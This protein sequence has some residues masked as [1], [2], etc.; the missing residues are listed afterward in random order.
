VVL[1]SEYNE[2]P[3]PYNGW[4]IYQQP[5]DTFAFVPQPGNGF[6]VAGPD[7]PAHGNLIVASNWYHL[8]VTDD[9]T[10]F[11]VYINGELR[12][13]FAVSGDQYIADGVGINPDGSAGLGGA[14]GGNFVIGQRTDG[15]WNTFE[16][17]VDDTAV[18]NYALTPQQVAL[19]YAD[20]A[21]LT[22]AKSGGNAALTWP[23][24][25]L[26]QST[27]LAGAFTDVVGAT[28][29]YTNSLSGPGAIFYRVRVP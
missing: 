18:Y 7:D 8:V 10:N 2:Y 6:L 25:I 17:T 23:T 24:G 15:A 13:S 11:Y 16:G 26:Q 20:A 1:S 21:A 19:H 27:N 5:N 28:S 3:F 12:T 14:D 4:Y 29:P 9:T 22:I